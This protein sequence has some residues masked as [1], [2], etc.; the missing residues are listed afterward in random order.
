MATASASLAS[1]AARRYATALFELA[2]DKGELT[3]VNSAFRSFAEGARASDDLKSLLG[4]PQFSRDDKAK[5]LSKIAGSAGLPDVLGRFLG[6]MAANGRAADIL[7]T[8]RAFDELYAKQRG[9]KRALARTAEPMT[10]AQREK[11]EAVLAKAVGGEI[12]LELE[13]DPALIGG[14]QLRVGS[15]LVDAT[16]KAQLDRLN[17]AMKG[18]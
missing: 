4:S 12:E 3:G 11:L 14:V 15:T 9:V 10:A 5:A 6:V 2:Q 1:E 13:T 17:T 16:I 8:Q 18:A 7:E